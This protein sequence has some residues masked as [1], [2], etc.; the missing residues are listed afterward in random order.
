MNAT[1]CAATPRGRRPV[2]GLKPSGWL[3]LIWLICLAPSVPAH[4]HAVLLQS[5]PAHGALLDTAPAVVELRFNEPISP[6]VLQLS[7]PDGVSQALTQVH[8]DGSRLRI[9]VPAPLSRGSHALVWRV[10]SADGHP[11]GGALAF[12]VGSIATTLPQPEATNSVFWRDA[13]LWLTRCLLYVGL[14]FGVASQAYRRAGTPP[15][16]L[17]AWL[18]PL[19]LAAS[20]LGVGLHGLDALGLPLM[21]LGTLAPWVGATDT[22]FIVTAWMTILALALGMVAG[23]VT[24]SSAARLAAIALLVMAAGFAASGHASSAAPAWLARPTVGLHAIAVA[25]WL[26]S[27]FPLLRLSCP[28]GLVTLQHFSRLAPATVGGVVATGAV[29]IFLQLDSPADVVATS[30][31]RLLLLKLALVA[32]LMGLGASNRYRWTR[33]ALAGD[34]YAQRHLRRNVV[35][36]I[37]LAT[38]ILGVVAAW[39][40]TP[41]P[42]A[43]AVGPGMPP[44]VELQFGSRD[45]EARL[46]IAAPGTAGTR[47]LVL[48]LA[49]PGGGWLPAR[50]VTVSFE[51][52]AIGMDS[53]TYAL[54][55]QADGSW[56]A[57]DVILPGLA[58]WRVRIAILVSDFD[59]IH[60][61]TDWEIHDVRP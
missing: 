22:T 27:F 59:R 54:D 1:L 58:R 34:A 31:G 28:G 9:E 38:L 13:A 41:P 33:A 53:I 17:P 3:F 44:A 26:G 11:I 8:L 35:I 48:S 32:G 39:R 47:A 7:G 16:A 15:A 46:D 57:A 49:A 51:S 19:A 42:R 18:L 5:S 37:V 6:L 21:A 61:Q 23:R 45:A 30:Y 29:L 52:P 55:V 20:C 24:P 50:E 12:S 56:R 2:R 36:E 43:L 14:F 25:L 60:L 4:A 40:L 10:V